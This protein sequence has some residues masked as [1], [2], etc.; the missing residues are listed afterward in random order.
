MEELDYLLNI[1]GLS[2]VQTVSQSIYIE[3]ND[4]LSS[5]NGLRHVKGYLNQSLYISVLV[6][7]PM[8]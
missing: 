8:P 1:D 7:T 2:N 5:L 4:L 6:V 3:D